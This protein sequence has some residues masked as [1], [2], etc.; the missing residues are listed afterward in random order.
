MRY[1]HLEIFKV[2][3]LLKRRMIY[4]PEIY[5]YVIGMYIV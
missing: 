1:V 4:T 5:I 3:G 2:E